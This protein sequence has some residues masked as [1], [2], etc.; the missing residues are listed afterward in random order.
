S[1]LALSGGDSGNYYLTGGTTFSGSNGTITPA[2]LT[3]TA[4]NKSRVYGDANPV[5]TY[6]VTGYQNSENATTA[7]LT[8]APAISTVATAGS[9]VGSYAIT[10]AAGNL[11]AQNYQFSTVDAALTV[12]ARPVT[13]T[14]NNQSRSYGAANPALTY[15]VAADGVG[16]SRGLYGSDTLTGALATTATTTTGV[17]SVPITQ[18]TLTNTNNGN[19]AITFNDGTLTI[20]QAALTVTANSTSKTYDGVAYTGG[21][22]VTY[23][24]F[25]NGETVA[26]LGGAL[27]FSGTSQG[28]TNVGSYAITPGG[29]SSV[30]YALTY[31][32]G[33]LTVNPVPVVPV[34][35]SISARLQ[36]T[37]SKVYDGQTTATLAP[38]N[39]LLTG[40]VGN[41]GAT[42]TK[43]AGVYDNA[44]A[45]KDKT[46]TVSLT[47]SD[48]SPVGT[49][50]LS[51][52]ILPSSVSGVVGVIT[53]APLTVTADNKSRVYGDANPVFTYTVTGYQNSENA[54]TAGLTGAPAISTVAT[55]GSNV[56][57]YAITTAAGNLAAQN[58]QFSTVDAA[59]TVNARPITVT[60]NNQ[61]RSYGAANPA[62]TYTVA[63]DGVGTSRGLYGSDT[64]TGALATT[65]TTTTGVGSVPITQ[66]TLTNTNNGNYAITFN[67]GTLTIG[68]AAL[69]VIA[70]STSKTYDGVAY[71]GG[72]GV[73]YAGFAN[74]ETVAV[75]GGALTF[76][77]T[78]Q[79]ATNV[80]SYA[81][82]PGGLS[83]VN[84]ALTYVDGT[85]TVNPVPVVPVTPSISARLQGTVSKVY[86]G[87]TT[88]TLA[89]G[90]Y[91]LTGWVGNDGATVTKT[92]GVYDNAN[93]GTDKTV[94]VSLTSS[95]FS[96]V[97]TTRLINY[98]LPSS[99]SGVV[100]VI[101]SAPLTVTAKNATKTYD[102]AIY[103]GG[104]GVTYAG[105]VNGETPA[106]LAGTLTYGGNSQGAVN[107]GSYTITPGG[108]S[109]GNYS[110]GYTDGILTVSPAVLSVTAISGRLQGTV[111]KV[112]DGQTR[113][114]LTP[115]NYLLSGWLGSDGA[116]VTQTTGTYD[117]P[118]VGTG[119]TV[120]V[121]LSSSDYRP[122]GTTNL[123]NYTLPTSVSGAVGTITPTKVSV[124]DTQ[125][126]ALGGTEVNIALI[127]QVNTHSSNV[128]TLHNDRAPTPDV[129]EMGCFLVASK[130]GVHIRTATICRD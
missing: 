13:V 100:G 7:G 42:V 53:P 45:G 3:V 46:V 105:F 95:D 30:N 17:G 76:S 87:Q 103:A 22:G 4:D 127:H 72:S 59:L 62:L 107:A 28:A 61:S 26:V 70:N 35:P 77:G 130:A 104:N 91:L 34:T 85:L 99:V 109:S 114:T 41:D 18:G 2:T 89:P 36:G 66:G 69:T 16:T 50:R 119:K 94:T 106:V 39:Y 57:S 81:I 11:A 83:S 9:N 86:D 74:G 113:A 47:S 121:S 126:P 79:G 51:N 32:D 90:N 65:A 111:S 73:T 23:A 108:L 115:D 27:T 60:A 101:T 75:L 123:Q 48:F 125:G 43:T 64:L 63:A 52:Y 68:Q 71:T 82:T 84:Y 29:L 118:N 6:T 31:V 129:P 92:A 117:N 5:F 67:D 12:N 112:Y 128:P 8:G 122:T 56:G 80:G 116:T 88:A 44:N 102:G 25:A 58:Y 1:N 93:A 14:A 37:V 40:W 110:V 38:G 97:G 55:A 19:Y 54:T 15:T 78:S 96:P 10:T 120:T 20:G 124:P 98:I 24:G 49:T 33:T 21:S